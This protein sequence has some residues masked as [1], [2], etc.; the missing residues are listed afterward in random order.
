MI[1]I[2]LNKPT[3]EY[4]KKILKGLGE[5][6]NIKFITNCMTRLR[7]VLNDVSKV[8]EDLLTNETGAS[9]VIIDGNDV[10]IVYG[11]HINLIKE[12][13]DKEINNEKN[14]EGYI[15]NINVKKIIE[16]IGGKDNIESLTNCM[17][18]LRLVLKDTSKLNEELL[19]NETKASKVIVLDEH[20][21]HIIYGLK[22]EDVRKAIEE[23]LNK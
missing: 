8:N 1:N 6:E 7:L 16:G 9:K 21:A 18:R 3:Q 5:K 11:L 14:D 2:D 4:A 17:T 20:N 15:N 19:V 12:A 23:E 22:I 13:I 10:Q